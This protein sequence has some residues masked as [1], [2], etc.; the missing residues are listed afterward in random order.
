MLDR[1]NALLS[2]F[3]WYEIDV[4]VDVSVHALQLM[5]Q[6]TLKGQDATHVACAKAAGV[7]D[8]ASFDTDF[9]RVDGLHLWTI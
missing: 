2:G 6:Y 7:V 1:L 4:T 9:R 3:N 5:A 8:L